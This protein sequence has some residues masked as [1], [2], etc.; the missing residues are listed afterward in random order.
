MKLRSGKS[1][2][3]LRGKRNE[4]RDVDYTVTIEKYTMTDHGY[5]GVTD[6]NDKAYVPKKYVPFGHKVQ[7]GDSYKAYFVKKSNIDHYSLIPLSK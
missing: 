2:V 3:G 7:L 1:Y 5:F 4:M 6:H